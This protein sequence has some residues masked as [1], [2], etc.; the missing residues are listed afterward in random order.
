MVLIYIAGYIAN[1]LKLKLSCNHC[2]N[3]L[4]AD[5]ILEYDSSPDACSYIKDLDRGGLKVPK[6]FLVQVVIVIFKTF[7]VLVS[8][9]YEEHLIAAK[10]QRGLLCKLS[11]D[12]FDEINF[13]DL[14]NC[15]C[16]SRKSIVDRATLMF[17]NILLNN[18]AKNKNDITHEP[19]K[20]KLATYN[21]T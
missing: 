11:A 4:T 18:Y 13:E 5:K 9:I 21:S 1:S 19:K 3:S 2:I 16:N 6:E 7:Q 8:E 14:G 10:N 15:T 12:N 17:A 20:R